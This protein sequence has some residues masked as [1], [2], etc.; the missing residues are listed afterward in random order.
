MAERDI[1]SL[2]PEE[3]AQ[4]LKELGE[5]SYRAAQPMMERCWENI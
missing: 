3:L 2:Y 5:P 4:R 1:K